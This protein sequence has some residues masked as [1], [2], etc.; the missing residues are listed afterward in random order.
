VGSFL[1]AK[2]DFYGVITSTHKMEPAQI[3]M[4]SVTPKI[5]QKTVWW[6]KNKDDPRI[7]ECMREARRKYYYKNQEKEK[8]RGRE[9]RQNYNLRTPG[10]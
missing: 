7:V 9:Y 3:V 2:F 6:L 5:N 10:S 4:D 1:F 8:Q